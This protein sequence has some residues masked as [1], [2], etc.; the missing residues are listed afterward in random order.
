M[1]ETSEA[2]LHDDATSI[3]EL[4]TRLEALREVMRARYAEA[5]AVVERVHPSHRLSAANLI[6]YLV[7]RDYDMRETQVQLAELGLSSLGR[8]EEHVITTLERVIDNLYVLAGDPR[9]LRT[10]SAVSFNEGRR[11]L[12]ANSQALLG[13]NRPARS[14]RILVTMPTEAA[15]DY[16]L[17]ADLVANGMDDA[18]INCAHDDPQHWRRIAENVRRAAGEAGR[19]CQVLM[20]VPGPKLRTGPIEPGPRVVRLRPRRDQWGRPVEAARAL[21]VAAP[22]PDGAATG[23]V[24]IPVDAAWLAGLRVGDRITLRDTRDARRAATVT[25]VT[26]TSAWVEFTDTTYLAT[27]TSLVAPGRRESAVGEL[28]AREQSLLLRRGDGV[29]L[30]SD[31]APAPALGWSDRAGEGQ[32]GAGR[33]VCI[34][35]TLPA[36]LTAASVGDRVF[37]DDGKIGGVVADVR[38][39]EVDVT[40]SLAAP[41]GSR[42]R[43]EKGINLPDTDLGASALGPDDVDL[44]PFIVEHADVVALSFAQ[45]PDDVTA[46]QGHLEALGGAHLGIVLKVETVRGFARLPAMLLAAMA[47]E[48][49]GVMVARGDLAVECGFERLAEVQEEILWLC[50][51]AHVPVIWATQVLDQMA[52]TGQPSRAEISDAVMAGRAECVMLNKGPHIVEAVGALDDILGRMDSYQH[53]KTAL[54]RRLTAWTR[55]AP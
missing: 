41:E 55:V 28:P 29:T 14:A 23:L 2:L 4:T 39:G 50:E 44:L 9:R 21:F 46:L 36:A 30:T 51:A 27:G 47:S 22:V 3:R 19:A 40:I 10:E 11:I 32:L 49:V 25:E 37:F 7:L 54:L 6:D 35:C 34:G 16:G 1:S 8:A 43:A 48:R 45:H 26:G 17:V 18:R 53:K 5:A 38:P 20:D 33:R 15:D 31:L 42:L 52:R 13:A 24:T 12:A